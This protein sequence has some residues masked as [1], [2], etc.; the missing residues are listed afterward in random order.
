MDK[1]IKQTENRRNATRTSKGA[2]HK[3]AIR[4]NY[5]KVYDETG[6]KGTAQA[7]AAERVMQATI[8][9]NAHNLPNCWTCGRDNPGH[10]RGECPRKGVYDQ[11]PICKQKNARHPKSACDKE[12]VSAPVKGNK[13][14]RRLLRRQEEGKRGFSR[15]PVEPFK[16]R[17]K[18]PITREERQVY[19][20]KQRLRSFERNPTAAW[21]DPDEGK[22][23]PAQASTTK[24]SEIKKVNKKIKK[25]KNKKDGKASNKE[26][27]GQTSPEARKERHNPENAKNVRNKKSQ[28]IWDRQKSN[29]RSRFLS[30]LSI[31]QQCGGQ[32]ELSGGSAEDSNVE[33]IPDS[34]DEIDTTRPSL[35]AL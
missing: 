34:W 9:R 10:F 32:S 30:D 8:A 18:G 5:Q 11:C 7:I 12:I 17:R 27:S 13:K 35:S 24:E 2:R 21:E 1:I 19:V 20:Y 26:K 15:P 3:K 33:S 28:A 22:L 14:E 31:R 4:Q 23:E 16:E 6:D 29:P 25:K